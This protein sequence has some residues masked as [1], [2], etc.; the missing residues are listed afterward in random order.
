MSD[1]NGDELRVPS[2]SSQAQRPQQ[3]EG[4]TTTAI[5]L[6]ALDIPSSDLDLGSIIAPSE[7]DYPKPEQ[8]AELAFKS[9]RREGC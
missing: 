5:S 1:Y 8:W 4:T 9:P 6:P 7:F 2:D 3:Q